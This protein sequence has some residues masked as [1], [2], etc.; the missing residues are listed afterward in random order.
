MKEEK[1]EQEDKE[2]AEEEGEESRDTFPQEL[3]LQSYSL[4]MGE[5]WIQRA[6]ASDRQGGL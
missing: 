4:T 2:A 6:A 1:N 5:G 3:Y